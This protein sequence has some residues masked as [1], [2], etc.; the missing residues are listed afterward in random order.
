MRSFIRLFV[1]LALPVAITA[2]VLS[3]HAAEPFVELKSGD[4][5]TFIGNTLPERMQHEGWLETLIQQR[6]ADK[7]LVFRNLA[8]SGDELDKRPRSE[9]FGSPQQWLT[10]TQTDVV[11]AFF[12]YNEAFAGEAGL[13]S[14]KSRLGSFIDQTAMEKYNGK[15]A[16]K[17]VLFGPLA[18]EDLKNPHLPD[19]KEHNVA[20]KAYSDAMAAVA[21]EKKVPFV[22]LFT[23]SLAL[24]QSAKKPLTMN[25]VHLNADGDRAIG[26]VIDKALFGEVAKKA[27]EKQLEKLRTAINDKNFYWFNLYRTVDGYNVFGGRS[28]LAWFGQSNADVMSREMEIF[29]VM[30][31]NRDKKVWAIARGQDAKVDDS[32]TPPEVPVK[33]NIPGPLPGGKHPFLTGVGGIE[34]MTVHKGM[35]VNLFA[36][37]EQFPDV[38]NPVQMAVDT[39]G[40]LFVVTWP[41]YPHWNPKEPMGDKILILP[42]EDRD[43]KADKAIVFA[44]NLNSVTGLEFWGG[45]VLVAAAPEIWFLKD[46]DG[47]D[48]A[49]L[50]LRVLQGI[51]AEDTH[52]TANSL[53][54]GPD[55]WLYFSHGVF[56]VDN[57]ETPTKTFRSQQTGTFRFNPRTYE[58]EFHHPIGPNPHGICFDQWGYQFCNDGTGGEG[59]YVSIGKGVGPFKAWFKKR[60]RPVPATGILSSR[61]FPPENNGNFLICNAIGVLGVLQHR[62]EYDGADINAVEVEPILIS[63]DP[64]FRPTDVEVAGD[65]A[66]YVS[67]W[68]NPIVGHMQHN[69]RDPNRDHTHGRVYRV[70]YEGRELSPPLKLKGKPIAEVLQAFFI[71]DN[72]SRY[73]ARLE[74]SG[75]D[76][77]EVAKAIEQF[78]AKITPDSAINEQALLE[79]LWVLEEHRLPNEGLLARVFQAKEPRV[80]AA[81]IRTLGHW[82]DKIKQWDSLLLTAAR[83]K[84]PLVRAEAAKAA[85]SF[86]GLPAAETIFEVANRPTD[87][88]LDY[89]LKYAKGQLNVDQLV[90]EA[91]QGNQKLSL[92]AQQYVLRNAGVNELL[93]M[94]PSEAVY[95]AI[96]SRTNVPA[97]PLQD[98]LTGLA[99]LQNK[100]ELEVALKLLEDQD[101]AEQE[102]NLATL[103]K[104]LVAQPQAALKKAQARIEKLATGAKIAATRQAAFAAWIVADGAPHNAI[105]AAM[106]ST[107][108]LR[109]LLSAIPM[110]PNN[111]V[112]AGMYDLV[113]QLVFDLPDELEKKGNL[114]AGENGIWCD[115][116]HPSASDVAL[117]TLARL[118][119][120][121]SGLAPK[122]AIDVPQLQ[123]RDQFAMRFTGSI[124]I[125][126]PGKYTF[127]L[128]S[129]DGSRMYLNNELFIDNDGLHGMN[130]VSKAVELPAG[131]HPLIVT[132][133]DNGGGDGL[134]FAYAGP[135]IKKQPVPT[136]KLSVQ[137][138]DTIHDVAIRTLAAVPGHEAEKF[139]DLAAVI[140]SG[141]HRTTAIRAIQAIPADKWEPKQIRPLA[142]NLVA[143]LSEIPAKFRTGASAEE[144]QKLCL[145]LAEKL[146]DEQATAIRSRLEN[147]DV[148]V[149]AIGTVNERMIYDKES[150]AVEAGKPVEFRFS[151]SDNMPHNFAIIQPGSLEEIGLLAEA[152]ARTPDAMARNYIPKSDKVLIGS[153]LLQ[154]GEFQAIAFEAPKTPGVYPYVCTYP[155]HWRRMYGALYVVADVREYE[156]D[157]VKYLAAHPLEVKDELLKRLARNTEWKF[158]DLSEPAT[159]LASGHGEP[160]S[161]EVGKQLFKVAACASC[162][163]LGG[164][165]NTIGPDLAML[166]PKK[167]LPETLRDVL[168]PSL[169]IN[170]KFQSYTFALDS[171]KTVTGLIVEETSDSVKVLSN[172]LAPDKPTI[173][174]VSEIEARKKSDVSIMPQG[175]LNRLTQEEIMDLIAYVYSKGNKEHALFKGHEHN[176]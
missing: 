121:A 58:V 22:D 142:D 151:N 75:R 28:K 125:D 162:H 143:Y 35:K 15:S 115:Y 69:M 140:K 63:S 50:K 158:A 133:F 111:D 136:E 38:I 31:Q 168:E 57:Q 48:K 159:H 167:T 114:G 90:K 99:K 60:V 106:K 161:F 5:I 105:A 93:K 49:D 172:P 77:A 21:N 53:C 128:G 124:L 138:D 148:R 100:P 2:T 144:A 3:S 103:G 70:T 104:L 112:R 13:P 62:V 51:S 56:H 123:Q 176:H 132:Y 47:D 76:S 127:F 10:K 102:G 8:F 25:G 119:P 39:D 16:P 150:I 126:K 46:T 81:A 94:E 85:V 30:A 92:A 37:E 4:H 164:E 108:S 163:K 154:P 156:A 29:G 80:R 89:V 174:P 6:Y 26:E 122:I 141:K 95:L 7:D 146:P 42:D 84:E 36:S 120:K 59:N 170:E 17:L 147:L 153:R 169:K 55:G 155:G 157:P 117:E 52:H 40:R 107:A 166:D 33:T 54:I 65:G 149:L 71:Q 110:V 175:V 109:E 135:G 91:V 129:D 137:G 171:G 83:D 88:Q 173:I 145:A 66:L 45:G 32:N 14:F 152:T 64:N 79:C 86:T 118:K 67:D 44:D 101:A 87:V 72:P 160:R 74:L 78:T 43:G 98:A 23:P 82:G 12:G 27:D 134:S 61:H 73:R 96:L 131:S 165:G 1:A 9:N 18:H 20:L 41:S 130:E 113:R 116:F 97:K 11:F 68:C 19:G 24:Y 139:K 34:K